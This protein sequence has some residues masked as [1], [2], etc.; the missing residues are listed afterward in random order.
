M[1][2]PM[3][4]HELWPNA[5]GLLKPAT[6]KLLQENFSHPTCAIVDGWAAQNPQE[7]KRLEKGG[8]LVER[9][10]QVEK[11][12]MEAQQRAVEHEGRMPPLSSWELA[13]VYGGASRIL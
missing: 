9:M 13:E 11:E 10:K 7:L 3:K 1:L 8:H 2:G 12:E 6:L 4:T 5:T